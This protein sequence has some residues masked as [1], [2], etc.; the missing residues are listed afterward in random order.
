[1]FLDYWY[2]VLVIP[3][4]IFSLIAQG[5]VNSTYSKYSKVM[6][7]KGMTG[8]D[9]AYQ[10]LRNNGI[11]DVS[12]TNI[13]GKLTDHYDPRTKVIRLSE[14]VFNSSSVAALGIAAHEAGHAVQHS[15]GYV[16]IKARNAFLP[17]ANIGS[18]LSVPLIFIGILFD[19]AALAQA[20]VI[21][22]ACVVLFQL[23]TLPVEFNASSR[24]ITALETGYV[25]D[26]D[27]IGGTKKV[28]R[29]AAMTYVA[30]LAVSLAQLLRFMILVSGRRR[31]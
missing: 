22:F 7:R 17:I 13:A 8:Q 27:E 26:S 19:F 30:G 29:A 4:I 14:D 1:M 11:V 20:G 15:V 12:V 23:L 6:S 16:P 9:M 5:L 10:I 18:S 21:F 31:R 24:A 3:A 28:L 25:L 2:I